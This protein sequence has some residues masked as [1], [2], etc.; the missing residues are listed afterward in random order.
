MDSGEVDYNAG[1]FEKVSTDVLTLVFSVTQNHSCSPPWQ[2]QQHN[3]L[4]N[5][6]QQVLTHILCSPLRFW[7]FSV[8]VQWEVAEV[9]SH[10]YKQLLPTV[11]HTTSTAQTIHVKHFCTLSNPKVSTSNESTSML[12][13]K[14]TKGNKQEHSGVHT[15][16]ESQGWYNKS[17]AC[18][19]MRFFCTNSCWW[20]SC[21]T[22]I[23]VF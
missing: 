13:G 14:T 20:N 18:W 23:Y 11:S 19:N 22:Y 1:G 6:L 8:L 10:T 15:V 2:S 5:I 9:I 17:G 12:N 21:R 16:S 3:E 7:Y 4:C